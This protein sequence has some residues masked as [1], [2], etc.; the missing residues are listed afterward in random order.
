M[1]AAVGNAPR[2]RAQRYGPVIR[3]SSP[4]RTQLVT[5][6]A[7]LGASLAFLA[8]LQRLGPAAIVLLAVGVVGLLLLA[9]P[10]W[11]LGALVGAVILLEAD[12]TSP[13]PFG[14][15]LYDFVPGPKITGVDALLALATAAVVLD[16]V[17]R[18]RAQPVG[19]VGIALL[20]LC[21]A[22]VTGAVAGLSAGAS[23]V[24][25]QEGVRAV[26]PLLVIPV[27]TVQV[28]DTLAKLRTGLGL[29]SA[30]A[31]LK[32]TLGLLLYVT[33]A[34]ATGPDPFPATYLEST[35]NILTMLFLLA[36][37][38]ATLARVPLATWVRWTVPLAAACL[39]LSFRRSFWIATVAS[40]LLVLLMGTGRTG[41]RLLAPGLVI[42]VAAGYLVSTTTTAQVNGPVGERIQQLSP[43][44]IRS[45]KADRYRLGERR[46]V[47]ADVREQPVSGLGL[48]V[49]WR[50]RYPL[51]EQHP[52]GRQYVHFAVLWWWMKLGILGPVG[53]LGMLL[54]TAAVGVGVWRRSTDPLVAA[55][56]LSTA[57]GLVGFALAELTAT[58]TGAEVRASVLMG[59]V[60]GLMASA[61]RITASRA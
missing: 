51:S 13:I 14:S 54:T 61:A 56:A 18:R 29:L 26:F 22:V 5:G 10:A 6:L 16:V 44:Q 53:Y 19:P 32:V 9:H 48:G 21:C 34:S 12:P 20:V 47:W 1:L 4:L 60:V 25:V 38:A 23:T 43:T 46:S 45:N 30:A 52:G 55:V 41:R 27:L 8:A 11:A 49:G 17:R 58:F 40:A 31:L 35:P 33:G 36:W 39:L 59:L 37:V 42:L 28:V 15:S 57:T 3:W 50:Q 7:A 2:R 24:E